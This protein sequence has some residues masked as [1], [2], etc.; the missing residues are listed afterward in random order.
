ME[1][2]IQAVVDEG[3]QAEQ[4]LLEEKAG[5][6]QLETTLNLKQKEFDM[7]KNLQSNGA[8]S[9]QELIQA[10]K[11]IV[12][13]EGQIKQTKYRIEK[14]QQQKIAI[15]NKKEETKSSYEKD[16]YEEY[17]RAKLQLSQIQD[18]QISISDKV[19]R[20][21]L[22]SP[23]HGII[24]KLYVNTEG[25]VLRPGDTLFEIVPK[26]EKLIIEAKVNPKD[27]GFIHEGM[28]ARV[29]IT[30]YD[31]SLYGGID[32]E[33]ESISPDVLVER[34]QTYYMARVS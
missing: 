7:L 33:V 29:K 15:K 16:A 1:L 24:K 23:V 2:K 4:S 34:D 6:E 28:R 12:E 22:K 20:T 17:N 31:F 14:I 3:K 32:G 11:A 25:G 9:P 8:V 26:D 27:I 21:Q 30:A 10:E 5:L 18:E 19:A 13:A